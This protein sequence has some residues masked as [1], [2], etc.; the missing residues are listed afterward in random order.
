MKTVC[1][2]NCCTGCCAC[3]A[4]CSKKAIHIE[5]TVKA[6]NAVIDESLCVN[7][8]L[9]EKI[10]PTHTPQEKQSP[11]LW[12][13]GW[14]KDEVIR[15][16][17][18][19]GGIATAIAYGFIKSGGI[20][21]SC[22]FE[23]GSFVFDIAEK[24]DELSRFVGSKYVK[25]NPDGIYP[26]VKELLKN[27]KKV[28]FIGLACQST[29]LQS[30]VGC[31]E[32]LYTVDLIC[33]GTPSP[34]VLQLFLKEKKR[35]IADMPDIKFRNKGHYCLS[36]GH[37]GF[38]P[39]SVFDKY[40]FAFLKGLCFT[41]NCYSCKYATTARVSDITLGDSWGSK[42]SSQEQAKGI[43]LVLCQT[44]KGRELLEMSDIHLEDVDVK[45]AVENN[46]QLVAPSQ[47]P[48]EYDV[49]FNT[50]VKTNNFSK[51]VNKAYPKVF[52]KQKIKAFLVSFGLVGEKRR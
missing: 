49:F 28:L 35:N 16:K 52:F 25:S 9:C 26:K 1:E 47:K 5:D 34:K 48:I 17:S 19:S 41:E 44:K 37:I 14:A 43:S 22:V 32:L 11:I 15:S 27:E 30:F 38:E 18:S 50:F 4:A 23:K 7:C 2:I 12:K 3:I 42:L 24:T 51:S 20:V 21:C 36:D 10:C 45:V 39:P 31:S 40:T 33:H 8:K 29:A 46:H 6:Y 13:Q